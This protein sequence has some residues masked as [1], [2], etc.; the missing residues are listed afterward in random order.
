[1]INS[2]W[3]AIVYSATFSVDYRFL[4]IPQDFNSENDENKKWL[5]KYVTVTTS[6]P[7]SLR[8]TPRWSLFRNEDFCV[9][10]VTS[11]LK[12]LA[13]CSNSENPLLIK[14]QDFQNREIYGFWG[15]ITQIKDNEVIPIPKMNLQLFHGLHTYVKDKWLAKEY[16]K[17]TEITEYNKEFSHDDLVIVNQLCNLKNGELNYKDNKVNLWSVSENEALWSEIANSKDSISLCLN[18]AREIDA[19]KSDFSNATALDVREFCERVK[20]QKKDTS[21]EVNLPS[22]TET[23]TTYY[24]TSEEWDKTIAVLG[25]DSPNID[26]RDKLQRFRRD[27]E[28]F[29]KGEI[30]ETVNSISQETGNFI[31]QI[32]KMLPISSDDSK[33]NGEEQIIWNKDNNSS[34]SNEQLKNI[35]REVPGFKP[36]ENQQKGNDETEKPSQDKPKDWF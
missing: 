16:N 18:L 29:V 6:V 7:E 27:P 31:S 2:K 12:N 9:V 33:I 10:G 25:D 1:M 5:E 4:A 11:M 3:S 23:S 24:A 8:K 35:R 32:V 13:K 26:G 15:Y 20:A 22:S 28:K 34:I 30:Q 17:R 14:T 36:K 19:I 21:T